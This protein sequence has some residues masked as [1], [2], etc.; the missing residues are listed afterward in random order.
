M[1]NYFTE[2]VVNG[3]TY[4]VKDPNASGGGGDA[5]YINPNTMSAAAAMTASSVPG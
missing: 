4:T 2:M 1:P 3:V 5:V